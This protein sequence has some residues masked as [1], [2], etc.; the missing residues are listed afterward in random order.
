MTGYLLAYDF[1]DLFFEK[2]EYN[3]DNIPNTLSAQA[4]RLLLADKE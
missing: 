2:F 1:F 4:L 3:L